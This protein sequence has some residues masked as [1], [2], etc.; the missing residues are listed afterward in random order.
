MKRYV[1]SLC[2]ALILSGCEAT[3]ES[4]NPAAD[5]GPT[6]PAGSSEWAVIAVD[7]V[8]VGGKGETPVTLNLDTEAGR[9]SGSDGCNRYTGNLVT[10]TG[11]AL[12][13]GDVGATKRLC[14]PGSTPDNFYGAMARVSSFRMEAERLQLMD[15]DATVTMELMPKSVR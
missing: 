6:L 4:A 8:P 3:T 1:C 7:G 11:D 5:A 14:P 2:V 15:G 12:T 9:I 13:L 10:G